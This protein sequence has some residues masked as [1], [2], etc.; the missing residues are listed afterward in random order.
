MIAGFLFGLGLI[1]AFIL[2]ANLE[3]AFLIACGLVG[4]AF[5]LW[6]V[7]SIPTG[8]QGALMVIGIGYGLYRFAKL[9]G[10]LTKKDSSLDLRPIITDRKGNRR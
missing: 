2:I 7:S 9:P 5:L 10:W 8:V 1:A 6:F 3:L 4:F